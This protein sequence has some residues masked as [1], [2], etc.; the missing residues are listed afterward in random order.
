SK[1]LMNAFKPEYISLLI[2]GTRIPHLHCHLIPKIKGKDNIFDKILDLHH[3]LQVRI[4]TDLEEK[5]FE[6]IAKRIRES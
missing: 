3:F 6:D 1:K 4:K 2:R 5:D